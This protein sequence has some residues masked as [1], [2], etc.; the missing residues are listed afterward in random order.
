[1]MILRKVAQAASAGSVKSEDFESFWPR[2]QE[3]SPDI[4]SWAATSLEM[5]KKFIED[6][7]K[8]K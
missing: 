5:R 2:P 1:M 6:L 7:K 3:S 4:P 8:N